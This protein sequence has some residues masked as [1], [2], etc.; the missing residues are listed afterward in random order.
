MAK[1]CYKGKI[2]PFFIGASPIASINTQML[3]NMLK[4]IDNYEIFDQSTGFKLFVLL[5]GH[6]IRMGL[7]F[8]DY[9]NNPGHEWCCCF[10]VPYGTRLW[11]VADSEQMNGSFSMAF[12]KAKRNSF[13]FK[14]QNDKRFSPTDIIPLINASWPHSFGKIDRS[15]GAIIDRGCGP[16]NFNC[17]L[18]PLLQRQSCSHL[19]TTSS[20]ITSTTATNRCP[21]EILSI[22][23]SSTGDASHVVSK[24][25]NEESKNDGRITHDSKKAN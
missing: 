22:L 2:L 19:A 16:L 24:L 4:K 7:P 5:D 13:H 23:N 17:L 18:H 9:I 20:Y 11:Q 21:T 8:L 25:F 6:H 12:A 14:N 10:G 3:A 1:C 15:K